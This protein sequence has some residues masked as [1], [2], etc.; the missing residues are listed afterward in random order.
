MGPVQCVLHVASVSTKAQ[1][2]LRASWQVSLT[3][4]IYVVK[5]LY[6]KSFKSMVVL[7]L[8]N[9]LRIRLELPLLLSNKLPPGL[10]TDI[11]K[12]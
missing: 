11:Q 6:P 5:A 8:T 10:A 12:A 7:P 3:H 1:G 9:R 2:Q 4:L